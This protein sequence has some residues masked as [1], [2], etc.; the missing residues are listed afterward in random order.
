MSDQQNL[1][2]DGTDDKKKKKGPRFLRHREKYANDIDGFNVQDKSPIR[3]GLVRERACT[4]MF[5]A[6]ALVVCALAFFGVSGYALATG[7][8]TRIF[9]GVDGN[10]R[11]CGQPG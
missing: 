9:S 1:V 7:N 10:N 2:Q 4:D 11:V 8:P 5:C 6:I 3:N